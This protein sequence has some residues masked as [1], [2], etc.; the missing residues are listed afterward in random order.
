MHYCN[1]QDGFLRDTLQQHYFPNSDFY[2][3]TFLHTI[4]MRKWNPPT[5]FLHSVDKG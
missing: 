4:L 2:N 1:I 5:E 3:S